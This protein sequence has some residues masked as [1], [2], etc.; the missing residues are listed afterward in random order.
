MKQIKKHLGEWKQAIAIVA[1]IVASGWIGKLIDI[2]RLPEA[3][4]KTE[5]R[6]D[7]RY[8]KTDSKIDGVISNQSVMRIEQRE[9]CAENIRFH[10]NFW[11]TLTNFVSESRFDRSELRRL[12]TNAPPARSWPE[13]S[14]IQLTNWDRP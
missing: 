2:S 14:S 7:A 11:H 10:A 1:F 6:A 4:K 8:E 5:A 12:I 3:V 9:E 13:Y